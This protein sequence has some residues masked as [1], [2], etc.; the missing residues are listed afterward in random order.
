MKDALNKRLGSCQ[1]NTWKRHRK[2]RKSNGG[3]SA[4]VAAVYVII[5]CFFF[6]PGLMLAKTLRAPLMSRSDQSQNRALSC[7]R[8]ATISARADDMK[9]CT[10]VRPELV[11][12]I[13]YL[14]WTDG[15]HLRHA[16][17][18]GLR[19]DKK[20]HRASLRSHYKRGR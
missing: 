6:L 20:T 12:W 4:F 2:R 13:E 14:E 10:W 15:D 18:D 17:F 3:R 8:S 19:E 1:K 16:K 11:A 5:H 9:K 7:N